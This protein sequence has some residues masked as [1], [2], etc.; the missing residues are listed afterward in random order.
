MWDEGGGRIL[1]Q[2]KTQRGD[3]VISNGAATVR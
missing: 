3:T 2:A 1:L